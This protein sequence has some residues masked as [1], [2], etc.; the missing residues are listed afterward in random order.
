MLS[1]AYD[2]RS[3]L[4][5]SKRINWSLE[6][7]IGDREFDFS[8][9]FLPDAIAGVAGIRCLDDGEKLKLNHIRAFTYLY[10]FGLVEEY[11][12]P[13]VLDHVRDGRVEG[14]Q[15]R[16][17]LGFA[18]EEAKHIELFRWFVKEFESRFDTPC[19]VI[20]PPQEIA[21]AILAHSRLGVFLTTLHIEWFT[22]KHYVE[23]VKDNAAERLDP[24][25]CSL[26]KHHWMEESQH[27]KLD[28][29]VVDEIA[30][31][32][33]KK[34]IEK[35]IDDYMDI[36][37]LLDGGLQAQVKMDMESLQ[38][39]IG[40][41]LSAAE[42]TEIEAAQ[43]KSYRWTFLL[44]GMT[45]PNFDRSLRELSTEGHRRVGELARAIA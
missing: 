17:L 5:T 6:D 15:R 20:G 11:I 2:Y 9:P 34:E 3:I 24:L 26:L 28:T 38:K 36:G 43:L 14:D 4:E 35:G 42:R 25:F 10:L 31:A 40:R 18:E 22:Q 32:L 19:G 39:A 16:A 7:V 8:R 29:L 44:S 37:K 41:E 1:H 21:A 27:A 30:S 45:H 23:S 33:G 13:S 12:V